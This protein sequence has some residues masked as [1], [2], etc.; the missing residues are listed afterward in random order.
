MK[1]KQSLEKR[2]SFSYLS[3]VE[4]IAE[5]YKA[6]TD[7]LPGILMED[8]HNFRKLIQL[9]FADISKVIYFD[10][11]DE[12][13]YKYDFV[14]EMVADFKKGFI[15]VNTSGNDS[16]LWGK[17]YNLQFRA[18]HDFIHCLHH[19]HFNFTDEVTAYRKQMAFSRQDRYAKKFPFLDW[20]MYEAVLRSEI[21]YQAAVKTNYKLIDL[22]TQKIVLD[23]F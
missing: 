11:V 22:D 8:I 20:N 10:F 15:R 2:K 16:R 3:N 1:S 18:I 19:L 4:L 23:A 17:V 5:H 14:D 7:N 13:P 21:I 9:Q 12:Y 6:A